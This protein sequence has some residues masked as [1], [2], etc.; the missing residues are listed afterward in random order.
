MN[1]MENVRQEALDA[2][3]SAF[4]HGSITIE[5]YETRAEKIQ[6]AKLL[7]EIDAQTLG[8]PRPELPREAPRNASTHARVRR[9]A[10]A[11]NLFV[12]ERHGSPDFS[13]C[14]MGERKLAGDW[15]NS[16]QATSFTLMGSTTLDLRNTA[17]PPGRLKI[18][19][20]AVMGEIRIL[21]P[22][23]LPVRMSAFPFMGEANV[24]ASVE[25]RVDRSQP[26][27]DVSG[28]AFMGSIIVKAV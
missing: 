22:R 25:Q 6:K 14:V 7:V 27:V 28:V 8:L 1:E 10:P 4:A 12:E 16:D 3:T 21:V 18:D 26:W 19:A 2:I 23:G 20:I 13:L 17:L 9:P 11:E 5:D 15:L 24:H